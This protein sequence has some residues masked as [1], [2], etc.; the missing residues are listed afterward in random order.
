MK[1][2]TF[3]FTVSVP[4]DLDRECESKIVSYIQKK[5]KHAYVVAEYGAN[6]KRHLHAAV[7]WGVE[8]EGDAIAGYMWKIVKEYHPNAIRKVAVNKHVMVDHQWYDQYLL[9]EEAKEVLLDTYDKDEVDEHFPTE[10][11]QEALMEHVTEGT[12][13]KPVDGYFSRMEEKWIAHSPDDSSWESSVRFLKHSMFV[14]RTERC[15]ADTRRFNQVAWTLFCYRNKRVE[16]DDV[17]KSYVRDQAGQE[18]L[19]FRCH[20]GNYLSRY[21]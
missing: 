10:E 15:I 5:S 8:S 13:D 4:G 17:D 7:C 19:G 20:A 3:R 1:F 11:Q 9:K 12:N 6:I 18:A 21:T 16:L 14:S 2:K